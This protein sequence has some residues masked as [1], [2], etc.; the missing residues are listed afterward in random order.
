L[1]QKKKASEDK[2]SESKER[3][4][5][6]TSPKKKSED[7]DLMKE[8][9]KF[10]EMQ[11]QQL[12]PRREKKEKKKGLMKNYATKVKGTKKHK[13]V[14]NADEIVKGLYIGDQQA[15]ATKE[16]LI[17]HNITHVVCVIGGQPLFKEIKYLIFDAFDSG[18]Q[19]LIS[20][21]PQTNEFISEGIA[22]GGVIV[23]CQRG[24]SRSAT[25]VIAYIMSQLNYSFYDAA[26]YVCER[27]PIVCPNLGFIKQLQLYEKMKFN[28]NGT[29][30]SHTQYQKLKKRSLL[31]DE[32]VKWSSTPSKV[33]SPY[34]GDLLFPTSYSEPNPLKCSK[35]QQIL[36]HT[37]LILP[38]EKGEGSNI[39]E[40]ELRPKSL[41]CD[42]FYVLPSSWMK[43]ISSN[44]GNLLCPSCNCIIGAWD[45]N[46]GVGCS[47]GHRTKPSFSV[48]KISI[49]Q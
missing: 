15:A 30:E 32:K 41:N 25:V 34:L 48:S 19:D 27:R 18:E 4:K 37:S 35:C 43:D 39:W 46:E 29:S 21:F 23:H 33:M 40:E 5:T 49:N 16:Q 6:D 38:H 24:I 47:C 9:L 31:V 10:L 7:L 45:W 12:E 36:F 20:K 28:L 11:K 44:K 13:K 26:D 2:K 1:K 3:L 42:I 17:K 14:W 22:S 8:H